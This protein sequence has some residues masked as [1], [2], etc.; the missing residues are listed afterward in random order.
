[1]AVQDLTVDKLGMILKGVGTYVV[2]CRPRSVTADVRQLYHCC[3]RG[4]Q[5]QPDQERDVEMQFAKQ[6]D[7]GYFVIL[8]VRKSHAGLGGGRRGARK[9]AAI[10]DGRDIILL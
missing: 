10:D 4:V 9:A 7:L 6:S 5:T 2:S 1:M 3:T 8:R